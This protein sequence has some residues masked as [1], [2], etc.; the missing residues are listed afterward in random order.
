MK[1]PIHAIPFF[2]TDAL[3]LCQLING[4]LS[5]GSESKTPAEQK[6][7]ASR[8]VCSGLLKKQV[9]LL[10]MQHVFD[11]LPGFKEIHVLRIR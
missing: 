5:D 9:F 1:A 8:P 2:N 10:Q 3:A 7:A 11:K 6:P 4:L